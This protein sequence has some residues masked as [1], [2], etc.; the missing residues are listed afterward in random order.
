MKKIYSLILI[1][2]AF[3]I[4]NVYASTNTF[5][6]RTLDNY[7]VNK[8]WEVDKDN[9]NSILK[10]PLVDA[11]EKV[12]DFSNILS[13]DDEEEIYDLIQEFI[14]ETGMD[15]VLLTDDYP[16]TYDG[17]NE[18]Y[19]VDFYDYNDFG[20]DDE[21]YSGIIFFR[22]TYTNPYYGVY[23][24]GEAQ[25]YYS[26]DR[27]DDMLDNIYNDIHSGDYYSGFEEL[28]NQLLDYYKRGY[29]LEYRYS[30][31]DDYGNIKES[32]HIPWFTLIIVSI[33]GTSVIMVILV[34]KNHMIRKEYKA[35]EYLVKDSINYTRKEDR[36]ITSHTSSYTSSSSSGGH[37]GGGSRSG[38]SGGGHSGGGRHG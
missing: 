23:F 3:F 31:I 13:D 35:S 25:L 15:L 30:Y 2:F 1:L 16:Y 14:D 38:S 36:F 28:T 18:D 5:D 34:N 11:D 7:G 32:Y 4:T 12:Y 9:I 10:T 26:E 21:H 33:I 19:A 37:S 6:R 17:A 27:L 22:N 8:K 24:F 29:A 20:I